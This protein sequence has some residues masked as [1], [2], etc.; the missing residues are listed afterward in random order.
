MEVTPGVKRVLLP[1]KTTADLP[2]DIRVE[3]RRS[4]LE[5]VKVLVY[6]NSQNKHEEQHQDYQ[7]RTEM[8]EELLRTGDLSLILNSPR[9]T[10][11]GVYTCTVYK[12]D[13]AILKQKVVI[14]TIRGQ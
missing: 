12:N 4:D 11:S 2:E 13:G 5:D 6:E 10:D 1:F 8:N 7:G 9:L 3:W 14:L